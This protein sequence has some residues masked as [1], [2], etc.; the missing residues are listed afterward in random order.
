M[1]YIHPDWFT[2]KESGL[3]DKWNKLYVV[4]RDDWTILRT[5]NTEE[6][7]LQ[8]WYKPQEETKTVYHYRDNRKW[9]HVTAETNHELR[10][11]VD[12]LQE[13][14]YTHMQWCHYNK[15]WELKH[16]EDDWIDKAYLSILPLLRKERKVGDEVYLDIECFRLAIEKHLPA[17]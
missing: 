9:I 6:E 11:K 7:L 16:W 5:L 10:S 17:K 1:N 13:E 2:T 8:Y 15:S 4:Y 14:P 3:N 12:K